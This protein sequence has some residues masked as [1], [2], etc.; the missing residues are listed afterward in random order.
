MKINENDDN[1]KF[2]LSIPMFIS[3]DSTSPENKYNL[4]LECLK[5]FGDPQK[6]IKVIQVVGTNGKGSTTMYLNWILKK[7]YAKVATFTSPATMFFYDRI[8]INNKMI[9]SIKFGQ[10]LEIIK[11][12]INKFKLNFFKIWTL[13]ALFYFRDNNINIAIFE[14]GIGGR[15]DATNI[16]FNT[17]LAVILTSVSLDHQQLLGNT[18][19][20]IMEEKLGIIHRKNNL[21][22]S[23]KLNKY[24]TI[25]NSFC[26]NFELVNKVKL[27]FKT[28]PYQ[29]NNFAL[30]LAA[31]KV[32]TNQKII[33]YQD[34]PK[35]IIFGRF[36]QIHNNPKVIID[37][38]HNI[39]AINNLIS[40]VKTLNINFNLLV[41]FSQGKEITKMQR[42]LN[43][44]FKNVNYVNFKFSRSHIFNNN[45]DYKI[46]IMELIKNQKPIL[47]TGSLYF[48]HEVYDWMKEQY[49]V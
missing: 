12:F 2:I 11:P 49:N 37:G 1:A 15:I 23:E 46:K 19:E 22:V 21:F 10:Y 3:N 24:Q 16:F 25:I 8:Q 47:I 20:K 28:I 31:A 41:G 9:S 30:A 7:Y 48:I 38:A 26:D 14:A 39:E 13:I 17:Q 4:W 35:E 32:I 34:L 18:V 44:N 29:E 43:V 42:L 27:P 40:Y 33:N 45:I 36:S 5:Y 6:K